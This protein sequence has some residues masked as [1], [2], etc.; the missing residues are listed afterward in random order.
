MGSDATEGGGGGEGWEALER[1]VRE[2][3]TTHL[4]TNAEECARL[5]SALRMDVPRA[6][7]GF[8]LEW[9]PP[10]LCPTTPKVALVQV[11]GDRDVLLVRVSA[12]PSFPP[13]LKDVLEDAR[14]LKAGVGICGDAKKLL[15][16]WHVAMKGAVELQVT[17]GV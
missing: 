11:S 13:A 9:P 14:I 3:G 12:M 1:Y 16:D 2:A 5:L 8:D 6:V 10:H 7:L 15:A 17:F 4:V